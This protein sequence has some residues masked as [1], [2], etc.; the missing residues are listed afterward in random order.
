MGA[1]RRIELKQEE[2]AG[3]TIYTVVKMVNTTQFKIGQELSEKQVHELCNFAS[4][5]ITIK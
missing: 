3:E 5:E 4:Y 2:V 1:V